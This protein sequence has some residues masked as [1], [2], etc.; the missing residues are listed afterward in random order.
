MAAARSNCLYLFLAVCRRWTSCTK[1]ELSHHCIPGRSTFFSLT[2]TSRRPLFIVSCLCTNTP[3]L[4]PRA[5]LARS[6][7]TYVS[8]SVTHFV[9]DMHDQSGLCYQF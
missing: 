3:Y 1:R 5:L 6:L 9:T 8:T 4:T 7:H 2:G